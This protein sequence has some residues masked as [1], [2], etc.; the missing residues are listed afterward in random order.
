MPDIDWGQVIFLILFVIV[1]FVRWLGNLMEQKKEAKER[2]SLSPEELARREAAWRRQVGQ[3][4]SPPPLPAPTPT[5]TQPPPD[6]FRQFKELLEQLKEPTQPPQTKPQPQRPSSSTPPPLAQRR[7]APPPIPQHSPA[8]VPAIP[9]S[10][11][12]AASFEQAFPTSSSVN[13]SFS[14]AVAHRD[15]G[16]ADSLRGLRKSLRNPQAVRE[17]FVLREVLGPPKALE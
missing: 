17:A 6:P 15:R 14:E 3:D 4:E 9:L 12:V 1:G 16:T 8:V 11:P 13:R 10:A 5:A 2:A 7:P